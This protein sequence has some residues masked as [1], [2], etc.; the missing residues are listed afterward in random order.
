MLGRLELV[1]LM[2]GLGVSRSLGD[3]PRKN[4]LIEAIE[5]VSLFLLLRSSKRTFL[6]W[7]GSGLDALSGSASPMGAGLGLILGSGSGKEDSLLLVLTLLLLMLALLPL[8]LFLLLPLLLV[9]FLDNVMLAIGAM[10]VCDD[11]L[12][13]CKQMCIG[14]CK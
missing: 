13:K 10:C 8:P 9:D 1:L 3:L 5:L 14:W 4:R 7:C 12:Y 6:A 2:L 11:V